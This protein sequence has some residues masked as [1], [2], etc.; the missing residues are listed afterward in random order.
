MPPS[1]DLLDQAYI[2]KDAFITTIDSD[3]QRFFFNQDM[4]FAHPIDKP[5]GPGP[6]SAR[7][8]NDDD[9][10]VVYCLKDI[11]S[12]G[13]QQH[14]D[15]GDGRDPDWFLSLFLWHTDHEQPTQE[16]VALYDQIQ[17]DCK[18]L[19]KELRPQVLDSKNSED[20]EDS[21]EVEDMG[22]VRYPPK[23][24]RSCI[25]PRAKPVKP[26]KP[27]RTWRRIHD[28]PCD[29]NITHCCTLFP[30]V[31]RRDPLVIDAYGNAMHHTEMT[32]GCY[33]VDAMVCLRSV[34]SAGRDNFVF[35]MEVVAVQIRTGGTAL[36]AQG[37]L[38]IRSRFCSRM[39][40]LCP[41]EAEGTL[42]F[43]DR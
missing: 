31:R 35:R 42:T 27:E 9:S 1:T 38:Q 23:L 20:S 18:A 36:P 5:R 34:V 14:P 21:E 6:W 7:I 28:F 19:W 16:T 22:R 41:K 26:T 33:R 24:V 40:E 11:Y 13:F 29:D 15:A 8:V 10:D 25:K 4:K 2:C 30:V 3:L 32:H 43:E 37:A 39:A 17:E 12:T